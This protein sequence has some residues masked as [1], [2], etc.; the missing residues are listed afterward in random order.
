M[1]MFHRLNTLRVRFTLWMALLLFTAL[2]LFGVFVYSRMAQELSSAVDASLQ[3]SAEQAIAATLEDETALAPEALPENSAFANIYQRGVTIRIVDQNG[4]LIKAVGVYRALVTSEESL[5]AARQG[6]SRFETVFDTGHQEYVRFYTT[7]VVS[8]TQALS[9]IQVAQSLDPLN[10]TLEQLLTVL[11]IGIP[12][13]VLVAAGG[14][15]L[16][17]AHTLSPIDHITR[18][19]QRISAQGLHE[20][21]NLAPTDDEVGRLASTFDTMLAR[22]EAAFQRERQFISDASHELRTPLTTIQTI[23]SVIRKSPRPVERYEHALDDLA[24]ETRRLHQMVGDLLQLARSD[25]AAAV[26]AAPVDLSTLLRD[27]AEVLSPLADEKA[28]ALKCSVPEGLRI[29]GNS[30]D[31]IR[32]FMNLID[33]AIKYTDSGGISIEAR[34]AADSVAVTIRD[35]GAGISSD[36]LPHVF[37]RFYRVDASRSARGTGL[38]LSIAQTIARTHRGDIQVESQPGHGTTLIVTLPTATG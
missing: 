14:G 15:Y 13:L 4:R 34:Q 10:A 1:M 5:A 28:L 16:L 36:H 19:A 24:G 6:G 9:I 33:N 23:I 7:S 30:D 37:D 11:V 18:T 29:A 2:A 32:L 22:L 38:G 21:L 12:L 35:T 31:L 27:V 3:L 8:G 17:V 20:R 25:A 26:T